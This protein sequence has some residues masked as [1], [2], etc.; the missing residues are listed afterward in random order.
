[1]AHR[2]SMLFMIAFISLNVYQVLG[3]SNYA[4]HANNINYIGDGLPE[5][6][7]LDGKVSIFY[8]IIARTFYGKWQ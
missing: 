2:L 1:M 3:Q 8:L 7:T 6:A 4:S 5:E